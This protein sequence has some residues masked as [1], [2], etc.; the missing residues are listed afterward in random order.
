LGEL[1]ISIHVREI[2]K[3]TSRKEFYEVEDLSVDTADLNRQLGDWAHTYN[4]IRPHQA[5]DYVTLAEYYKGWL[6]TPP[7]S[8]VSLM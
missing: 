4:Y 7:P 2:K 5:L 1:L 6:K 8:S 3:A